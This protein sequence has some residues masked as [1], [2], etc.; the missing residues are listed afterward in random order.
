MVGIKEIP[1]PIVRHY[2]NQGLIDTLKKGPRFTRQRLPI[3]LWPP[4]LLDPRNAA[5]TVVTLPEKPSLEVRYE[6]RFRESAPRQLA[7]FEGTISS[8]ENAVYVYDDVDVAGRYPVMIVD[9][10]VV[11]PSWFGVD[12]AFFH[13]QENALKR[14]VPLSFSFKSSLFGLGRSRHL[15][16][17]FLLL[18]ERG[19]NLYGWL[20]E[21]LPKLR[22]YEEYCEETGESPVLI[23]NSPLREYQRQ[24]LEWMGYAPDTWIEHGPEV[25]HVDKLAVAPHPIR[26]EGRPSSGYAS[27][28]QWVGERI[29]S[30]LPEVESTYSNRIY[31]SRADADR[32]RVRNEQAVLDVLRPKGFERYEPGRLTLAEQAHLFSGADVIVGPHGLAYVNLIFCDGDTSLL[33]LFAEDGLKES[34]FVLANEY[35][36]RY[37]CMVCESIHD[38]R[39]RRPINKDI[40]VDTDRLGEVVDHFIETE[41]AEQIVEQ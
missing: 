41:N 13:H 4:L 7:N 20:H 14:V 29:V 21:T 32:R 28:L 17:A 37:E 40:V 3:S 38:G 25:T 22:W 18:D 24:S 39:N 15:E 5:D 31:V 12:T 6:G 34:Y 19:S 16:H 36:M 10:M 30:N 23:V 1:K 11:L 26:L 2:R 27:P 9:G 8:P 33:E 35:G